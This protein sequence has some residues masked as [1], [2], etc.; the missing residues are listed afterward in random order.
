MHAA[1]YGTDGK[2]GLQRRVHGDLFGGQNA[3]PHLPAIRQGAVQLT[4]P[5]RQQARVQP[6]GKRLRLRRGLAVDAWL[7]GAPVRPG[8]PTRGS[9]QV[10]GVAQSQPPE[11]HVR[12]DGGVRTDNK[13]SQPAQCADGNGGVR[14]RVELQ[15]MAGFG[16]EPDPRFQFGAPCVQ[17]LRSAQQFPAQATTQHRQG[18]DVGVAHPDVQA[19]Y[20]PQAQPDGVKY[21]GT[22]V[23]RQPVPVP[24]HHGYEMLQTEDHGV[25]VLDAVVF[26]HPQKIA[27][28]HVGR[29]GHLAGQDGCQYFLRENQIPVRAGGHQVAGEATGAAGLVKRAVLRG[30]RQQV[31]RPIEFLRDRQRGCHGC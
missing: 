24:E 11:H 8:Q 18:G 29:V 25:Q 23:H 6:L 30:M 14:G 16:R 13:A 21:P 26:R 28:V 20:F 31:P 2:P 10:Q 9:M 27:R 4:Q 7:V 1:G 5:A 19:Q 22:G 3:F 15:D 12:Q 17:N